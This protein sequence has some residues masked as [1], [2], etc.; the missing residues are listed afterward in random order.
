MESLNWILLVVAS[1]W[2]FYIMVSVSI[3]GVFGL[4]LFRSYPPAHNLLVRY[5]CFGVLGALIAALAYFLARVGE[6]VDEGF[7]GALDSD[8]FLMMLDTSVGEA[9]LIRVTSLLVLGGALLG[10][11]SLLKKE[12][13]GAAVCGLLA[14]V[15][16]G[17][18]VLS[19]TLTGHSVEQSVIFRLWLCVHVFVAFVWMG[20]LFPLWWVARNA[21][22]NISF[23]ILDQFG[24]IAAI[25]V[26]LLLV[27]GAYMSYQLTGWKN[28]ISTEYGLVLISKV[29]VVSAIM[30]L[31]ALNK[32]LLVPRLLDSGS[33]AAIQRSIALE[34]GVGLLLLLATGVLST[35]MGPVH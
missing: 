27:G 25:A 13:G 30:S 2:L 19:M 16:V 21:P 26:P 24:R 23:D 34:A 4:L 18:L 9:L 6:V 20:S 28:L 31:A 35:A 22:C 17:A 5:S 11:P 15:S 14:M 7:W 12:G 10:Y 1:R 32:L 8:V 29:V 33:S 3:G